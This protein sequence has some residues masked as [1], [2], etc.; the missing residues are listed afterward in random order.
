MALEQ[1]KY[2]T[3]SEAATRLN[4]TSRTI[5]N[6]IKSG[7]IPSNCLT[8]VGHHKR[9]IASKLDAAYDAG[10]IKPKRRN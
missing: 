10:G 3:P 6:W 7:L 2:L 8:Y 5:Y 4:V 1:G 9:I